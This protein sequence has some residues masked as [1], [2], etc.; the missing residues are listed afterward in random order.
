MIVP[1]RYQPQTIARGIVGAPQISGDDSSVDIFR[2]RNG[3]VDPNDKP[4][5]A[6][7]WNPT[8][9]GLCRSKRKWTSM[10]SAP[11]R[12]AYLWMNPDDM[13]NREIVLLQRSRES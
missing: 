9:P 8:R 12:M 13:N 2:Y 10:A 3:Q 7:T 11:E 5:F 1:S 4:S 6:S